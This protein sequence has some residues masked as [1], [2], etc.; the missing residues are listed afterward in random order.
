MAER[1]VARATL[2]NGSA[3]TVELAN[4][5][6]RSVLI[7]TDRSLSYR[8]TVKL[9]LEGIEM[10]GEVVFVAQDNPRGAV[11]VL[12]STAPAQ[13]KLARWMESGEV[14][15]ATQPDELWSDSTEPA[16]EILDE[17]TSEDAKIDPNLF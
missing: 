3:F 13:G 9:S 16:P 7:M 5:T 15:H 4:Q 10:R 11:L 17:P 14:L 12:E 2:E 1:I 8:E 6:P